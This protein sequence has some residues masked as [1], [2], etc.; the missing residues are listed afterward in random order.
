MKQRETGANETQPEVEKDL[1]ALPENTAESWVSCVTLD[2]AW[3]NSLSF[4]ICIVRQHYGLG[5]DD[6]RN[7]HGVSC[8]MILHL[9]LNM[10]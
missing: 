6:I 2:M 8:V 10:A 5:K 9:H 1:E 4:L 7:T 3:N